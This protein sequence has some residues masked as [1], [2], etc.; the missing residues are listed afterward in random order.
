MLILSTI[1]NISVIPDSRPL[2]PG[3]VSLFNKSKPIVPLASWSETDHRSSFDL[4]KKTVEKWKESGVSD[5]MLY[6]KDHTDKDFQWKL[7]PYKNPSSKIFY[8]IQKVWQQIKILFKSIFTPSVAKKKKLEFAK[9]LWEGKKTIWKGKSRSLPKKNPFSDKAVIA[10]QKILET[11]N[12]YFL[13]NYNPLTHGDFLIV[14]KNEKKLTDL[15]TDSYLEAMKL[16]SLVSE[17]FLIQKKTGFVHID[18][19]NGDVAGLTMRKL[20]MHVTVT[21]TEKSELL[22]KLKI[23]AKILLPKFPLSSK[24]LAKRVK[25]YRD[26]LTKSLEIKAMMI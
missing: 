17:V 2:N 11:K 4:I 8:K 24:E 21:P 20:L 14:S 22:A 5:Y 12:Y 23:L 16:V 18:I 15:S 3:T 26:I 25:H 1:E 13:Y 10:R 19:P 7:I 6:G 9:T